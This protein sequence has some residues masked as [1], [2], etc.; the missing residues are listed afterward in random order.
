M[1]RRGVLKS[2]RRGATV[3]V[4]VGAT[5]VVVVGTAEQVGTVTVLPSRVT[6]PV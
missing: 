3:V 4:V 2:C 1:G 6:A 5:V